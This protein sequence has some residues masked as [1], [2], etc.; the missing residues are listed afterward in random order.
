V[1][2]TWVA[3]AGL[4]PWMWMV[5]L[6]VPAGTV[7][8]TVSPTGKVPRSCSHPVAMGAALVGGQPAE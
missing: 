8:E 3:G 4:T 5:T 7:K 6:A 1:K 2:A